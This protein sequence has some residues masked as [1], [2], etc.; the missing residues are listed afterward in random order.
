MCCV[1]SA[2]DP[3]R[4]LYSRALGMRPCCHNCR[5]TGFPRIADVT[6]GDFW[7]VERFFPGRNDNRGVSAVLA[8]TPKGLALVQSCLP[9]LE[10]WH[11]ATD[12][13]VA[14][15]P[16]LVMATPAPPNRGVFFEAFHSR[17]FGKLR[18][19]C[20]PKRRG[21]LRVAR[22]VAKRLRKGAGKWL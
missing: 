6:L 22:A 7:G 12:Q 15:N 3:F 2:R 8:N 18:R 17:D 5:Y 14:G 1:T 13:I 9:S 11:A 4:S 21:V 16:N 20:R 10:W 19:Y